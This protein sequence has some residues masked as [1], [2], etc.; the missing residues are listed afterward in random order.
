M[1]GVATRTLDVRLKV[2]DYLYTI[3]RHM[4]KLI[5][6]YLE[7]V[8]PCETITPTTWQRFCMDLRLDF[9]LMNSN[10]KIV[11]NLKRRYLL[12]RD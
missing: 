8:Q 7:R 4:I 2:D 9:V 3:S 11:S 5:I 6:G 1:L 10:Q 12:L